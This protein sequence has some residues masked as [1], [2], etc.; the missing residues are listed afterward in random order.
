MSLITRGKAFASNAASKATAAKNSASAAASNAAV[1]ANSAATKARNSVRG[2]ATT[3]KNSAA[4]RAP[5]LAEVAEDAKNASSSAAAAARSS[6]SDAA[7]RARAAGSSNAAPAKPTPRIVFGAVSR[8]GSVLAEAVP[9]GPSPNGPGDEGVDEASARMLGEKMQRRKAPPGW[10]ELSG[11]KIRSIRMP[12]HDANGVTCYTICFANSLPGD[13]AQAFV[14]KLALMLDPLIDKSESVQ[15]RSKAEASLRPL[16][17]RELDNANTGLKQFQIENQITE[18]REIMMQNVE[19][20]LDRQE[21][22]NELDGKSA[23][24]SSATQ[25]FQT[26]SRKLRRFHLMNQVKWGVAIGTGVTLVTAAIVV[27]IVA[28]VA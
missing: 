3:A 27:P 7:A 8:N 6:T 5:L 18:V 16:L 23:S 11:G 24:L 15:D 26:G 10:D 22:L 20:M 9:S 14:Q 13:R 1:S 17:E 19:V 21:R 28:A 25:A 12:I 2:A 4:A